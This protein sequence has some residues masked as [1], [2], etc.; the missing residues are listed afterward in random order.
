[1][2][3]EDDAE[4]ED[5]VKVRMLNIT[6]SIENKSPVNAVAINTGPAVPIPTNHMPT[7]APV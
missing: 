1:M 5:D 4:G 2:L 7:G 3:V 6:N